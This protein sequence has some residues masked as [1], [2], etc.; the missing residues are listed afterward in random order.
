[1]NEIVLT[2]KKA[3]EA[4]HSMSIWK[5]EVPMYLFLG[6]LTAGI[7]L[8]AAFMILKDKPKKYP[9]STNKLILLAPI[10]L[11]V[12]MLFL[13]LDLDHKLYVWRF[14]TAF[15]ITSVMSWGAWILMLVYPLSIGLILATV[16]KGY[17]EYY[18]RFNKWLK[19]SKYNKLS[20]IIDKLIVLA[21]KY[22][23]PLAI[24]TIP[25]GILLGIY[26]GIL[27]S[28]FSARPFWNS[29]LLGFLFLVS[30]LSTGAALVILLAKD[31]EERKFITKL[32][33]G[34]IAVEA[35]LLV[36]YIFGMLSSSLQHID[37]I[38]LILGGELTP[39]FWSFVFVIGMLIPL[40]LELLELK[41]KPIPSSIA[42]SLV[43]AG[44]LALRFIFV[45]AG[46]ITNWL[47]Y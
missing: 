32:D 42:A 35:I 40:T 29:E 3:I 2:T 46:Q 5:W 22:K 13:F 30:G 47:P 41:G 12:G 9:F 36:L 10:I 39:I 7:L 20:P 26:T 11:S 28:A 1:M 31:H 14:Y 21:E 16:K 43:L 44:G 25:V 37:A 4:G 45:A 33:I 38:K 19:N 23:K 27:L 8:I 34:F 6:G 18:D 24:A 15:R 17:A